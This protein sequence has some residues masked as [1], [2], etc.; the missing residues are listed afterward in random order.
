MDG[1]RLFNLVDMDVLELLRILKGIGF[2]ITINMTS[3]IDQKLHLL[4][5][6]KL[7]E[8]CIK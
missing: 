6:D 2:I 3:S 4:F 5:N 1:V 8:I 7:H